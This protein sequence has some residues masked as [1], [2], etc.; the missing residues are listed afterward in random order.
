MLLRRPH[1]H[2][3]VHACIHSCTA[4][5]GRYSIEANRETRTEPV[6]YTSAEPVS[7]TSTIQPWWGP[8]TL[9]HRDR[10][11]IGFVLPCPCHCVSV[12]IQPWWGPH[13]LIHRDRDT[14][15]RARKNKPDG[16]LVSGLWNVACP[17]NLLHLSPSQIAFL[18]HNTINIRQN[19]RKGIHSIVL[20]KCSVA[21]TVASELS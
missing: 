7:S 21:N 13:T 18:Q 1:T 16:F 10:E 9:I 20:G 14:M 12:S 4:K 5:H 8:H 2:T 17:P 3:R 19:K 11:T 6:W 15:T